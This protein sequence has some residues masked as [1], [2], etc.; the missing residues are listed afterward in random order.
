MFL[1]YKIEL[2]MYIVYRNHTINY[3]YSLK[4]ATVKKV[5]KLCPIT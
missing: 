3:H 1:N 4:K 2:S 5:P